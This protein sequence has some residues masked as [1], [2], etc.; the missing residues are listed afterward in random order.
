MQLTRPGQKTNSRMKCVGKNTREKVKRNSRRS[1]A[2]VATEALI[3]QTSVHRIIKE[4]L[5]TYADKMQ[6][7]HELS[8]T[9]ECMRLTD[10][11]TF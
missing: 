9:H 10:V 8:T 3:S 5:R 7:R 6:K 11:N 2:I 4:D 1:A